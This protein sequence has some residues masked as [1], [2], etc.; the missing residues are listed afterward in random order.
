VTAKLQT[1]PL[2]ATK[3][4]SVYSESDL[5]DEAKLIKKPCVG[6]L[7]EG[8]HAVPDGSGKGMTDDLRLALAVVIES[9][10]IGNLDRKD[11]AIELLDSMRGV[12]KLTKA[13]GGY[14]WRFLMEAPVGVL[15]NNLAY[16]QRWAT[17]V[18]LTSG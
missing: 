6:I 8:I 13:P 18:I 14:P 10:D 4:F 12:M 9:K 7:Y 15:G 16:V 5:M 2:V 11:A 1:V 17:R 3:V